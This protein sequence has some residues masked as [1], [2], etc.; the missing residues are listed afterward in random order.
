MHWSTGE[1]QS[2]QGEVPAVVASQP[3]QSEAG[4]VPIMVAS[5][6]VDMMMSCPDAC[7]RSGRQK[8]CSD[9]CTSGGAS[10]CESTPSRSGCTAADA[11][12]GTSR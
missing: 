7:R 8:V 4:E 2:E 11:R 6:L 3:V 10:S 12:V 1:V 5:G 9:M